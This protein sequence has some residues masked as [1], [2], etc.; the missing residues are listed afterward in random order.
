TSAASPSS[1]SPRATP[2]MTYW[3]PTT[4]ARTATSP[5]P[6]TSTG[7]GRLSGPSTSSG[8]RSPSSPPG[9]RTESGTPHPVPH[10]L[11]LIEDNP[12]DAVIFREK[13]GAGPLDTALDH[14]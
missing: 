1:S 10:R 12:G 5:S 2:R 14:V 7:S 4:G 9:R 13:V 8:S 3:Q 11:L 6:S